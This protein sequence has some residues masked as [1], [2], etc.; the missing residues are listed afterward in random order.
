MRKY[1]SFFVSYKK[2][3]LYPYL[4]KRPDPLKS[5]R[6]KVNYFHD[7]YKP[8]VFYVAILTKYIPESNCG[9][10]FYNHTFKL[11]FNTLHPATS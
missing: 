8:S 3:S 2:I 5:Y 11:F 7:L 9:I 1:K 6:D 4:N 10:K